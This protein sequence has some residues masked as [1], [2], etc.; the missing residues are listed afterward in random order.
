M[1][2]LALIS[3]LLS[4][5]GVGPK[6]A[7]S[8]CEAFGS[9]ENILSADVITLAKV[10][11]VSESIAKRIIAARNNRDEA[12]LRFEKE[13]AKIEKLGGKIIS[14]WDDEYPERLRNIAQPPLLLYL[15]GRVELLAQSGIA[16][17]GTRKPTRYG[18]KQTE[19]FVSELAE[20]NL[21]IVSGLAR[22]IDTQA[23]KTALSK[24]ADTIAVLGS[25]LDYIY[26]PENKSL[27]REISER[28]LLVSEYPFG[29]KPDAVNFPKRNRI[30]SGLTL[31]TLVVE[32]RLTGG[33]LRTAAYA[34]EQ[35]REV[36]AVPGNL[37]SPQSEGTNRI[38]QRGEAKLVTCVNDILEELRISFTEENS[39]KAKNS[40]KVDTSSLDI[41][42]QKIYEVLTDAPLHIDKISALSG[43]SVSEC[44]VYLLNLELKG[45]AEQLPGKYFVKG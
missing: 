40:P 38:I 6:T 16:V 43:I 5:E 32:T 11:G 8:L 37:N 3:H 21:V 26:P 44:S 33:A 24:N 27:F 4:V 1:K 15:L 28:G 41:F 34:L 17:V 45:F 20:K 13:T 30:I 39:D 10:H 12:F 35:G 19:K 31:G 18:L 9:A 29:T 14:Y 42:E 22:G 2:N 36:F 7:I 23:H 25:G